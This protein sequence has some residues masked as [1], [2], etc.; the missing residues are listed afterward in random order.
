[1]CTGN[2]LLPSE[3]SFQDF[4]NKNSQT[5]LKN[6]NTNFIELKKIHLLEPSSKEK[7]A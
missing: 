1:M 4:V 3:L 5:I 7:K 2:S 6:K